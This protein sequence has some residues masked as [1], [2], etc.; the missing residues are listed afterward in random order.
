MAIDPRISLQPTTRDVSRIFADIGQT[1]QDIATAPERNRLLQARVTTAEQ[2]VKTPQ[3]LVDERNLARIKSVA[4]GAQQLL[5]ALQ[6]NDIEGA[7]RTLTRRRQGLV[8]A[9]IDTTDTDEALRLLDE[10]PALLAQRSQQVI[11]IANQIQ[12]QGQVASAS[13][14]EFQTLTKDLTP[15][16][17]E[18]AKR[19]KLGLDPRAVGSAVQT[20]TERGTA[21][22]VGETEATIK[23]R[24]KFGELTG[25]SRAKTIDKGFERI[26][27]ISANIK[28]LDRAIK[29]V[30][31][32]AG[33]GV[34]EKR[35]PSLKAASV[36]LDQ[37]QGQLALD[38]VGA[39]TFGA[40]SEGELKLAKEVAL[41]TGLD[42]PELIEHIRARQ[43]AQTKLRDYYQEQIDFLDQGGTVAGFLREKRRQGQT[44]ASQPQE[45]AR[46]PG[47]QAAQ[48]GG[49]LNPDEQALLEQLRGS[50]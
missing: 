9:G 27:K 38:V 11:N 43:A 7:R 1:V 21:E 39:V 8:D 23:E 45:V 36:E 4:V 6:A 10:N 37:I 42:G 2:A 48:Q 14:R 47:A 18:K 34:L 49:G 35:F 40:L 19:V 20:I 26:E 13:E 12:Q 22:Q 32:G 29:A 28:N 31:E 44:P 5:P 16:E 17:Q 15:E 41:P 46:Q 33:T 25:A 24:A 30:E 50:Q 3:Q